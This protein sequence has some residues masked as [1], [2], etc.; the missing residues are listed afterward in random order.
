MICK[1]PCYYGYIWF[2]WQLKDPSPLVFRII[3]WFSGLKAVFL[4]KKGLVMLF[5]EVLII[6]ERFFD[7]TKSKPD[8]VVS[9]GHVCGL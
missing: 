5:K 6:T 2:P 9:L 4:N 8:T 3:L 1:D 7:K